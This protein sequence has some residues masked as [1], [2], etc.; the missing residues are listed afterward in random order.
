MK[1]QII[2]LAFIFCT[3]SLALA[4]VTLRPYVGINSHNLT[5][6][7]DDADWKSAVGYQVGIDLQIG[8]KFYI[9]PGVQLEFAKNK[10][11]FT[12]P[13]GNVDLKRTHLRIPVMLGVALGENSGNF[14]FRIFTGPN[15][16]ILL[17]SNTDEI[18]LNNN[19]WKDA[20]FGW[21]VGA[22]LDLSIFFVDLG[23]QFGLSD[24]YDLKVVN[25][26]DAK[27]NVFYANAGL[28]V[29]F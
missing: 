18:D 19:S 15:A 24:V 1:K 28:R 7:F 3:F 4:Q 29:R 2:T 20:V 22:G 5:E 27:D 25:G 14:S 10:L 26:A 13:V 6:D 23:Y 16:S 11:D 17:D 12:T 8:G 21:N 9:Q